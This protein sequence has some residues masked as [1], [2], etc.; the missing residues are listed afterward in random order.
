[1][2]GETRFGIGPISKPM[3]VTDIGQHWA[4]MCNILFQ[5]VANMTDCLLL[6]KYSYHVAPILQRHCSYIKKRYFLLILGLYWA[7]IP[8]ILIQHIANVIASL[9]HYSNI[10]PMLPQC[11]TNVACI[12]LKHGKVVFLR[13]YAWCLYVRFVDI[14]SVSVIAEKIVVILCIWNN[15]WAGSDCHCALILQFHWF[16]FTDI[17]R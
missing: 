9:W 16:A 5:Y 14:W 11:Y 1:M 3:F 15:F 10:G 13:M 7:D 17:S 4:D 12:L 6:V 8:T 2:Y